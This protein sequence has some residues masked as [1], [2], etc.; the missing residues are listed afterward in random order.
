M[1]SLAGLWGC[2]GVGG[3]TTVEV[4]ATRVCVEDMMRQPSVHPSLDMPEAAVGR[5][6]RGIAI[7]SLAE[8]GDAAR[9]V[10][11]RH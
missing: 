9:Q 3:G 7:T 11:H 2:E 6:T 5:G 4:L 8:V 10:R 1:D